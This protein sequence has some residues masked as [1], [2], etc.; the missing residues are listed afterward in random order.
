VTAGQREVVELSC[1]LEQFI[2]LG[3][4]D[5]WP[6]YCEEVMGRLDRL[7]ELTNVLEMGEC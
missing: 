6:E 1:E 7:S 2:C 5:E 4:F 3:V